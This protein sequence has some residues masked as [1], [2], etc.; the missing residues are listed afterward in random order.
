LNLSLGTEPLED[1]LNYQ[2]EPLG[3]TFQELKKKGHVSVP[4]KYRKYEHHG[5]HTPSKKVE[6]YSTILETLGYDPLPTYAEPP[7]SPISTA[8]LTTEYPFILTTGGRLVGFFHTEGRQI[9]QLRKIHPYPQVEL[10]P[11]TAKQFGIK[12]GDWVNIETQRGSIQQRA[13]LTDTIDP[14]VI[15]VEHGWWFPEKTGPDHGV[16]ESNAN[17]LT[18]NKPPYDPAMGTYQLRALLCRI[19]R[20]K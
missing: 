5:F 20:V 16:W 6:L 15:H 10:N 3:L 1:I 19:S 18:S 7:E 12:S 8:D 4:M 9:P 2:L 13:K 14:R 11:K 17:L